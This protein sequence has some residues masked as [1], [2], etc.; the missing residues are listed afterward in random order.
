MVAITTSDTV[1][2]INYPVYRK[3]FYALGRF[4][5]FYCSSTMQYWATSADG[6]NWTLHA[7][8]SCTHGGSAISVAYDDK[9]N[10]FW[11]FHQDDTAG[12]PL[13]YRYGIPKSDGTITWNA[14]LTIIAGVPGT[15]RAHLVTMVDSE[16]YPWIAYQESI[17]GIDYYPFVSKSSTKEDG[18]WTTEVGFPHQLEATAGIV[19]WYLNLA[20]LSNQQMYIIYVYTGCTRIYGRLWNG[21]MGAEEQYVLAVGSVNGPFFNMVANFQDDVHVGY[22]RGNT[23]VRYIRRVYSTGMW[24]A[25]TIIDTIN[26]AG[27]SVHL[28]LANGSDLVCL[29]IDNSVIYYKQYIDGIWDTASTLWINASVDGIANNQR[30]LCSYQD[31]GGVVSFAYLTNLASPFNLNHNYLSVGKL[32]SSSH[33]AL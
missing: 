27:G 2:A 13:Y 16:G 12:A 28:A 6:E 14:E 30:T 22:N 9:H 1:T 25:E 3:T 31:G 10:C 19:T 24:D 11:W 26:V 29:W 23:D 32:K 33:A 21:S 4:W 17:N 15:T 20:S 18:V 5:L 8:C 7:I